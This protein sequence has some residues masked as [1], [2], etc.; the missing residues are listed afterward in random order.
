MAALG[1]DPPFGLSLD[2]IA[3]FKLAAESSGGATVYRAMVAEAYAL[4]GNRHEARRNLQEL[5]ENS[6]HEYVTPYILGR[7]YTAL[8]QRDEAFASLEAGWKERAAWMPFLKVDPRMDVR[9]S[10]PR[11]SELMNRMKF[12]PVPAR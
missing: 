1:Q 8:D 9:R 5:L 12:P 2:A 3:E 4:G 10:D 11:F 6:A 7:I